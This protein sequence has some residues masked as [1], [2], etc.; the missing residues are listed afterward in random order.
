MNELIAIYWYFV[1]NHANKKCINRNL[2]LNFSIELREFQ[3]EI[4]EM[5]V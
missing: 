2:S 3:N 1:L 5:Q 4:L